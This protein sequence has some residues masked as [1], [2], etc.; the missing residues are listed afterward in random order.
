MNDD[1]EAIRVLPPLDDHVADKIIILRASKKEMPMPTR[2]LGEQEAFRK[3]I[4][5]ELPAFL[6][7]LL[8]EFEVP[9][10]LR[11]PRYGVKA[12]HHPYISEILSEQTPEARIWEIIES[13]NL[14]GSEF[15]NEN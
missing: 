5:E 1:P 7:W 14:D 6:F 15:G 3:K 2:T 4:V 10:S 12:F 9:E 11:D 8:K 13:S